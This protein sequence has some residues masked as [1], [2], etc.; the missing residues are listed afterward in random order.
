MTRILA[1]A[2]SARE[3][4]LNKRLLLLG[5]Q[6]AASRGAE[7]TTVD[8]RDCD[9]ADKRQRALLEASVEGLVEVA[10]RLSAPQGPAVE[11]ER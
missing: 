1:F 6:I 9:L 4:S 2:G 5:A 11:T 8:L 10:T 7:V 3:A